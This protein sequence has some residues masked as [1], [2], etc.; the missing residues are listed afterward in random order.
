MFRLSSEKKSDMQVPVR[1]TKNLFLRFLCI[2]YLFAFVS[3]YIQAPG[4]YGDNGVLPARSLLENSKHKTL[5][6][7]I[8]YQPTL[9]WLAPYLGLDIHYALDVLSLLGS[10]LAFSGLISQ[11]LC[12]LPLFAGLWSLYFSLYQI[13][14][15]FV[16]SNYDDLLLEVGF[17][18]LLVAP[19][20]PGKKRGQKGSIN[21]SIR[22]W[23]LRW[24]LFRY[25]VTSGIIKFISGCPKWWSLTALNYHFQSMPLPSPLSWYAHQLPDW[26]LRLTSVYTNVTEIVLPF[27]FFI[28]MRNVRMTG[29]V[30]QTFLQSCIFL[31]GN[32]SFANMLVT[33]LLLSL[34]DDKCFYRTKKSE[35]TS[36]VSNIVNI[37]IYGALF[38]G[39]VTV[40][41]LKIE[42]SVVESK[43]AFTKDNF[44][45]AV[46][47]GISFALYYGLSTL[48]LTILGSLADVLFENH[49]W[50]KK[51]W[52]F[53]KTILFSLLVLMVFFS[54]T[55]PLTS[56]H[57]STNSTVHPT[58]R[59]TYNRLHK[60]RLINDYL[61]FTKMTGVDGR[62]EIVLE[63]SD[64]PDGPWVEY[65]FLYKPGNVNHSMPFV[66][67]YTPRLDWQMYWAAQSTYEKQP[68]LLSLTHRLLLG[69]P[70]VL[71]LLDINHSPF[72]KRPPKYIR[73]VLYKYK[74]TSWDQRSQQSWWTRVR[75]NEYFPAFSKD[76]PTLTDYL[77]ARNLIPTTPKYAPNPIWKQILD[78]IRYVASHMEATLLLWSVF[79]AGCAIISTSAKNK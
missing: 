16:A 46:R 8:H 2:V 6:A 40:F 4:L 21:D 79:T 17:I 56:L 39:T 74:Y 20:L 49:S 19:V 71:S 43:I 42:G 63:G 68:W 27:L 7:K 58:I 32:F 72:V 25:L 65:N 26:F 48:A 53:V 1:Y 22:F 29:F 45:M 47:L 38:Y 9:L 78:K 5:S 44:E 70:E 31:T 14:Q 55:V 41:S 59:N 61:L 52:S 28:P 11:K 3:F 37:L 64:S 24:M 76:S 10:F 33:S 66:A 12:T 13:G 50:M 34:L 23:L 62:R 51:L 35:E 60:I 36:Y 77:K 18:A 54:S 15:V 75:Q 73:G 30:F 67:P 69:T 57:S